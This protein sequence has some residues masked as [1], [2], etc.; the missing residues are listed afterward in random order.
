HDGFPQ[1][2]P[3]RQV[4]G[5]TS[6]AAHRDSRWPAAAVDAWLAGQIPTGL[7]A[8]VDTS[9]LAAA[10]ARLDARARALTLIDGGRA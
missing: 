4:G 2:L 3:L 8:V 9:H 1:P 7:V 6:R 5:T 10:S